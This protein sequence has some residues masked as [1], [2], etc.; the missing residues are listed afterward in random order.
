MHHRRLKRKND[1]PSKVTS[2]HSHANERWLNTPQKREKASRLKSRLR[3]SEKRVKYMEEKIKKSTEKKAV[4]VDDPLHLGLNQIMNDHTREI[5]KK[6]VEG[7]FHHLFWDQQTKNLSKYPTQ[8]RWHPMVIRWCLHLKMMSSSA[9]DV[10]RGI[11]TLPCGRTLQDYTHYIKAGV[12]IQTEVTKQLMSETKIDTLQDWQ[13]YVSVVFDEV[14]IK[15]GI[16][17]DKNECVIVGFTNLG[18]VNNTL[19][20]FE[21]SISDSE[22]NVAKQMLV[23]MV[24]GL[25]IKLRF[26]YAQYPTRGI[27][28]DCCS[29]LPGKW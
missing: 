1:S 2:T 26:P 10:L 4:Q 29:L 6:Y 14:K 25:F 21:Q 20:T 19:Q 23:F 18:S 15:E 17:F 12:G 27:T 8:R 22:P 9:Y 11:L 5:Q 16:V 13:K 24:R 3:A 28:A 7:S